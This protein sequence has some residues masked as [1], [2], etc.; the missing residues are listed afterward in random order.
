MAARFKLVSE[1]VPKGDQPQAIE[2]LLKGLREGKRFQTLLGV[3]GSGKTFSMAGVMAQL[4][5]PTLLVSHNKTLAAQLYS[6][7][8]SFFPENA[9]EYFVSYYDYYQP[10]AYIPQTDTYIEKDASINDRLDRLRLAST[11]SLMSREDAVIVASV[12]CIYNLGSPED[13]RGLLLFFRVGEEIPRTQLL[14]RLVGLLYERNDVEFTRGK[15]RVRGETIEVFPAY[16]EAAVRL[17]MFGDRIEKISVIHPVTGDPIQTLERFALYPA[18]H[19]ITTQDRIEKG[20]VVIEHELEERLKELKGQGKLLEA[21]RLQSRT[22]YDMEMM[23]EVGFCHGIENYSRALSGRP[24][25]S[26]PWCLLDYFPKGFLTIIDES[27]VTV[28][29]LKGMYE[30]DR[31]RKEILVDFGFRLPSCLD[32]R[33]L[34]FEEF[35]ERVGQVIFVSATP[36]PYELKVS[37]GEVVEQ[38]I[39]P[40]GLVDPEIRVRPLEG[41]VDDLIHEAKKRASAGERSLVTTLTKR[42]A[43]DLSA[44]LKEAGLRVTYIHS[45]LDAFERVEVLKNL[46][47]GRFDAVVGVNLLREGLDLPEVSLVCVMDADKEGFLRSPTSLIQV[48]GRAARHLHGEVILYADRVTDAMRQAMDETGRRRKIQMAYNE[49]HGITPRSVEKA[50]REGIEAV[51]HEEAEET[52]REAAGFSADQFDL[53]E[54]VA[55][56]EEEMELAA[57]NLQF[58][59]AAA[60]RD[61]IAELREKGISTLSAVEP[62]AQRGHR[63][64]RWKR[65]F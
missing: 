49:T 8:K 35:M 54:A 11:T 60:L 1:M 61:Q 9:V 13:Y 59:R 29:Q 12:S 22:Q 37:K 46:R 38:V 36:G 44:F 55:E 42:M 20:L 41:Q 18:K 24:P 51:T 43:E 32:N 62:K 2:K 64:K 19:F 34:K 25:G 6:E 48:S 50:I 57:R 17:Q 56:L 31:A 33:P 40:T 23:R 26:R 63:A 39:R 21:E 7:L 5:R 27:H 4:N 15:F 16:E 47:L 45:D 28:P 53:E 52:V 14:H 65:R 3:T 30:G 58:E 10:E